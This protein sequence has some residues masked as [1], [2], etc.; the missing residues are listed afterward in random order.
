MPNEEIF[1]YETK[2]ANLAAL[3]A[4]GAAIY[5]KAG[6]T[7]EDARTMTAIQLNADMRGVDTHGFQR[8][9][10]YVRQLVN[11][12]V[13]SRPNVSITRDRGV[14][15]A[16]DGDG[17]LGQIVCH[18]AMT[19]TIAKAHD[20]GIAIATVRASNDWGC[21]AFYPLMAAREGFLAVC[22]TTSIPTVAPYGSATR[23]TG[24]NPIAVAIPRRAPEAPIVLDMALT[25]VALGKVMRARAEG[26]AIP[27]EWGFMDLQGRPTTDPETALA[28]VIPAIG[29]YKGTGLSIVMNVLAGILGGGS[30]SSDVGVGKRG[31][32]FLVIRPDIFTDEIEFLNAVEDMA[33][34]VKNAAPLPGVQEVFLPG[35]IERR[36]E[37]RVEETGIINYPPSVIS[38]LEDVGRE[39]NVPFSA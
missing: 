9:P 11:G 34:Q 28:G 36:S 2:P 33:R 30:H 39:L 37:I 38:A 19:Y 24:N 6:M 31:Q 20:M 5:E 35:E 13:K 14:A 22:T 29:A 27:Q 7:A 16:I 18:R 8:L 4:F 21:G 3:E 10:Q 12:Q 26:K 32:F 17:G 23:V 1:G 15:L 25:P